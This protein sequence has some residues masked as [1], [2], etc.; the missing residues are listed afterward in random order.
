MSGRDGA[1]AVVRFFGWLLMGIGGL[2]AV[3][4]GACT[5]LVGV[6]FVL[7]SLT[8]AE[9]VPGSLLLILILGGVPLLTGIGIFIGGR[10]LARQGEVRQLPPRRIEEDGGPD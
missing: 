5:L 1:T 4:A 7:S 2:I 6:P 9:G 3:T 8:Y 10:V